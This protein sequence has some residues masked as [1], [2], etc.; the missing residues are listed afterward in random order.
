MKLLVTGA[1]GFVCSQLAAGFAARGHEVLAL[2]RTFDPETQVR[3]KDCTLLQAS[4]QEAQL[5]NVDVII[6]GAAITAAPTGYITKYLTED[7]TSSLRLL[8]H[9]EVCGARFIQI[10]S[11]AVF[12]ESHEPSVDETSPT[13]ALSPYAAAKQMAERAT[14]T[15]RNAGYDTMVVRFGHLY[16]PFERARSSRPRVSL[17][18]QMIDE[19]AA[20]GRITVRQPS[21]RREWT[22]VPDLATMLAALMARAQFPVPL[23]HL[24]TDE[25]VTEFELAKLVAE[26]QTGTE[27]VIASE[28]IERARPQ[29]TSCLLEG[30]ELP[31]WT[32]LGK[33]LQHLMATQGITV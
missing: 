32:P 16:G 2:D 9:S 5:P 18:Q 10:S 21:T 15:L 6:H 13:C 11:S 12:A 17:V 19:A 4:V 30:L 14:M 1:G 25:T 20:Q 33:G 7:V 29:F 24:A 8:T 26:R 31:S 23:L 28:A 3:L 22:F 27:V